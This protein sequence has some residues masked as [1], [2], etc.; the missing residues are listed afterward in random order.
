MCNTVIGFLKNSAVSEITDVWFTNNWFDVINIYNVY[1]N[2]CVQSSE[3]VYGTN[4]FIIKLAVLP[5]C[6]RYKVFK[7]GTIIAAI[8]LQN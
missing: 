1:T 2:N 8:Y 5:Y 4:I 3:T 6:A 7:I